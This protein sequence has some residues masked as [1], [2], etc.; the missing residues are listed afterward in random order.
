[1]EDVV[2]L[3][4]TAAE[5]ISLDKMVAKIQDIEKLKPAIL[6]RLEELA[7]FI[8]EH[9]IGTTWLGR[10]WTPAERTRVLRFI[11]KLN[12]QIR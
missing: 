3:I 2:L 1:M 11:R 6:E 9:Q 8:L 4:V 12:S 5:Q 10:A 7:E